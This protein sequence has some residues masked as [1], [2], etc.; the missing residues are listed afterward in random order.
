LSYFAD[1]DDIPENYSQRGWR[2][3]RKSSVSATIDRKIT[4]GTWLLAGCFL[5][6]VLRLLI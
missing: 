5:A 3:P 2:W 4:A 1:T 6:A